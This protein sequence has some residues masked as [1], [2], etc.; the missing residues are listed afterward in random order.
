MNER[1]A[2]EILRD[3][4]ERLEGI[5]SGIDRAHLKRLRRGEVP[6][7]AEVDLHGLEQP[8]ARRAVRDA[9]VAVKQQGGRCVRVIHGRGIHS[10][11]GDAVLRSRLPAWLSEPPLAAS[12]MAFATGQRERGG[13]TYVLLRR[14]RS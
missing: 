14:R 12:V 1:L 9:I 4:P 8:A 13:A 6:A 11:G 2:F 3:E 7:D 5:A 10:E